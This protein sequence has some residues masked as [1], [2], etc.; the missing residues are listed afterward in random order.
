[1]ISYVMKQS[2]IKNSTNVNWRMTYEVLL[3]SGCR[4]PCWG[5]GFIPMRSVRMFDP[6]EE[7]PNRQNACHFY[8]WVGYHQEDCQ[9]PSVRTPTTCCFCWVEHTERQSQCLMKWQE[10]FPEKPTIQKEPCDYLYQEFE[11]EL[12]KLC[13][14]IPI[15][16][17]GM[18]EYCYTLLKRRK[19]QNNKALL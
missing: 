4:Y 16:R 9:R 10:Q 11:V 1:M 7:C 6:Y 8:G 13:R 2:F 17:K 15:V 12:C 5:D 14:S 3:I 18:C 19:I